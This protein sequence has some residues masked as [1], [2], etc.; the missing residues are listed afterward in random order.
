MLSRFSYE[1]HAEIQRDRGLI[2]SRAERFFSMASRPA[3]Q[4]PTHQEANRPGREALFCAKVKSM[5]S[6][7]SRITCTRLRGA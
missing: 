2:P 5:W 1:L 7:T 3:D 6:L 4:P